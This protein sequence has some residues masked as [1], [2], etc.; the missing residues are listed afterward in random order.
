MHLP[1]GEE[2]QELSSYGVYTLP[3]VAELDDEA[4]CQ[5][6]E[7]PLLVGGESYE[8]AAIANLDLF[9]TRV[10]RYWHERGLSSILLAGALNLLALAF[11]AAFSIFLLLFVDWRALHSE[12]LAPRAG[13]EP[14]G[15]SSC[16]LAAVAL[17][18]R[19]L[20]GRGV[21][22]DLAA[23]SYIVVCVVYLGWT[24]AHYL[25]D[26]RD[27]REVAHFM[28]NKLG[29]SEG[30]VVTMTWAEVVHRLVLVQRTTRL[31]IS[32]D[33]D[34]LYIVSRIMRKDNYLIAMINRNVLQLHLQ[35]PPDAP[36]PL[37]RVLAAALSL[38][39]GGGA[40][41]GSAAGG[42]SGGGGG[43]G[44]GGGRGGFPPPMLTKTL[45]WN[46]RW[47]ILDHMFDDRFRIRPEFSDV[48]ALKRRLRF[49][50]V[51]NL[52]L[53]PFLL[54]FLLAYFFMRNAERLYHHPAALGSRRWSGLA[55]WRIREL[56]ELPHYLQHRLSASHPAALRYVA[57]FP[58]H[59]LAA[60]ARFMV[61]VTG[62]FVA[63]LLMMTF[64]DESLL[65]RPLLGRQVVWWLGTM[66]VVLAACRTLVSEEPVAYD[67]ERALADV[68]SYTHYLPRHWRGRAHT[69]EVQSAFLSLFRLKV[70]LFLEE[71]AS[72]VTTPLLLAC[73][74]PAC[75][76]SIVEFVSTFT[77]HVDGV[78]DVCSLA[79]F[80]LGRHGNSK[81]GSPV[82]ADKAFR[83]RQ[84]KLEKSF[85][86]FVATYPTWEPGELG[87]SMLA[88]LAAN[89]GGGAG[90]AAAAT[91]AAAAAPAGDEPVPRP[92][93]DAQ[94]FHQEPPSQFPYQAAAE[95]GKA[96]D[97]AAAASTAVLT[98][99]A[100]GFRSV[101]NKGFAA[102]APP[103]GQ[104]GGGRDGDAYGDGAGL[105]A[106]AAPPPWM[107]ARPPPPGGARASRRPQIPLHLQ[108]YH[109]VRSYMSN[110]STSQMSAAAA[111]GGGGWSWRQAA[112]LSSAGGAAAAVAAG[113]PAGGSPPPSVA[114]SQF[115]NLPA[116][117]LQ[118]Y[119]VPLYYAQQQQLRHVQ[120]QQHRR[121]YEHLMYGGPP[122]SG[123][124]GGAAAAAAAIGA[125]AAALPSSPHARRMAN[126]S[127]SA[128]AGM[129]WQH[130]SLPQPFDVYGSSY[131]GPG[132]GPVPYSPYPFHPAAF[133]PF[134]R[135]APL[136]PLHAH[137]H[138]HMA[139]QYV[140]HSTTRISAEPA[141][142]AT[143]AAAAHRP[144]G[145][146]Q[147]PC[148][149]AAAAAAAA[150]V[151]PGT[152][153]NGGLGGSPAAQDP[154]A[155]PHHRRKSDPA[156]RPGG[157]GVQ[158]PAAAD[159]AAPGCASGQSAQGAAFGAPRTCSTGT[160]A[161]EAADGWGSGVSG[162]SDRTNVV[163][164]VPGAAAA[165][166]APAAPAAGGGGGS[167]AASSSAG[168]DGAAANAIAL[169]SGSGT[170]GAGYGSDILDMHGVDLTASTP[171]LASGAAA[172]AAADD[173]DDPLGL[174]GFVELPPPAQSAAAA[175][176]P[177][178]LAAGQGPGPGLGH[179]EDVDGFGLV[180]EA[181]RG[182]D[183]PAGCR[184]EGSGLMP[185]RWG[186]CGSA[187][188]A[189][190][191][192]ATAAAA[193]DDDAGAG[194]GACTAGGW[195]DG[196][197][198]LLPPQPSGG[199]QASSSY[200]A[201][202]YGS[203]SLGGRGHQQHPLAQ[204][205]AAQSADPDPSSSQMYYSTDYYATGPY[206]GGDEYGMYGYDSAAMAFD[207]VGAT[208]VPYSVVM[209]PPPPPPP[210]GLHPPSLLPPSHPHSNTAPAEAAQQSLQQQQ[211][212]QAA[213]A[214]AASLRASVFGAGGAAPPAAAGTTADLARSLLQNQPRSQA[215]PQ[216]PSQLHQAHQAH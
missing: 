63:L 51:A 69:A 184:G 50:A 198:N 28:A 122:G 29:I 126:S 76:D 24:A 106:A 145:R 91:D 82:Q 54:M 89:G 187:G 183:G 58:S 179:L 104:D 177:P 185:R 127:A 10:Y 131:S 68:V 125:T 117:Y 153:S 195:Y 56:N 141:V 178:P 83:S 201:F 17:D 32:R 120:Q 169:G 190:R 115:S 101:A 172:A 87:S 146:S 37:R 99:A 3:S 216:P 140:A 114:S 7:T 1:R 61:F 96:A 196:D 27:M 166:A 5:H 154:S 57:Q 31:C 67:P 36:A 206:Y 181:A 158:G 25:L 65:E 12:C 21:A 22:A 86:T 211:Q 209:A 204:H 148:A 210:P 212:Q 88:A 64:L 121:M 136:S 109:G 71:L 151:P 4:G 42:G 182:S 2:E 75:A 100:S 72:L 205:E 74:L 84:G 41:G 48:A 20:L 191:M 45:E 147:G 55:K 149:A 200:G 124:G 108:P 16:D 35:P 197:G 171:G 162:I 113:G 62:S 11:T 34:E 60:L 188:S 137:A 159:A 107:Q 52:L 193:L 85:L 192:A 129:G 199:A 92:A 167:V 194:V 134:P 133:V 165:A 164:R 14:G 170:T 40:G 6:L 33:L 38:V 44:S 155:M 59:T 143:D 189:S 144:M 180:P 142:A 161:A 118:Y 111:G 46:L 78:G 43:G 90:G 105:E 119:P 18:R 81:Y 98:R 26:A 39:G 53:S 176:P 13:G 15:G 77:S 93:A 80:D 9:F 174:G 173:E 30:K 207:G 157:D 94:P 47:C 95:A 123:G 215:Q 213:A 97:A 214:A 73:S 70:G 138:P 130:H 160:T 163:S 203:Q 23:V 208:E 8:F 186:P 202:E 116:P 112:N 49:V 110:A 152:E 139:Q 102:A 175:P 19:P 128:A 66:T 79:T 135:S 132:P 103:L 168:G 150:S 156:G